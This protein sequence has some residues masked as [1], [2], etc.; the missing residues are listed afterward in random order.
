MKILVQPGALTDTQAAGS[1]TRTEVQITN[2]NE[3]WWQDSTGEN[4]ILN[5]MQNRVKVE[6]GR[7]GIHRRVVNV[8]EGRRH[9]MLLLPC[10]LLI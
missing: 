8:Q 1:Y 5:K 2:L 10:W 7:S 3:Q 6:M 4:E 9:K